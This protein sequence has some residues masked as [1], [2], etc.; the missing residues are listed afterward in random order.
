MTAR[1]PAAHGAPVHAGDPAELGIA[2]WTGPTS[3]TRWSARPGD[4]PVFWAC[5]VTPQAVVMASGPAVRRSRT[6]PARMLIT[7]RPDENLIQ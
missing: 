6:R 3:A 5:G 2:R 1:H 4:V 7:D